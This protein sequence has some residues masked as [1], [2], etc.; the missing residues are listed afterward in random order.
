MKITWKLH[1]FL[2]FFFSSFS[3]SHLIRRSWTSQYHTS[4][5]L[6][7]SYELFFIT[8]FIIFLYYY[9]YTQNTNSV[10]NIKTF[11]MWCF[12]PFVNHL[13]SSIWGCFK[14]YLIHIAVLSHLYHGQVF[15]AFSF[16]VQGKGLPYVSFNHTLRCSLLT[17]LSIKDSFSKP[18]RKTQSPHWLDSRQYH[19]Y[20]CCIPVI[21]HVRRLNVHIHVLECPSLWPIM[22]DCKGWRV[23]YL[24]STYFLSIP[25]C[26]M[27]T[28]I[29][30]LKMKIVFWFNL[31]SCLNFG[32]SISI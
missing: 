27:V 8:Y 7:T 24:C 6:S 21:C 13:P 9:I 5:Q 16:L 29:F 17:W 15:L 14:N 19:I 23:R 3:L 18:P 12:C 4:H 26:L 2:L 32:S 30:Q 28:V 11:V 10:L 31:S 1:I 25:E 22:G 20:G